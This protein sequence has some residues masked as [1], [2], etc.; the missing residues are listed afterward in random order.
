VVVHEL[1]HLLA[2][3]HGA[4]FVGLMDKFMPQWKAYRDQLNRLPVQ[5]EKWDY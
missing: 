4:A 1:G 3:G 5:H 2:P